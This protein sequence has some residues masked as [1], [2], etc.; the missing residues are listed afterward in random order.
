MIK[1]CKKKKIKTNVGGR[2]A[3]FEKIL[4]ETLF[5]LNLFIFNAIK[6]SST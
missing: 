4:F 1:T 3:V 6:D 2:Q 5:F